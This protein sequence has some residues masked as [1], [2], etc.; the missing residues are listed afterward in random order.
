MVITSNEP[1]IKFGKQI[2]TE[3]QKLI[4]RGDLDQNLV[5]N[6]ELLNACYP[7]KLSISVKYRNQEVSAEQ[8]LYYHY[9]QNL[10]I[11]RTPEDYQNWKENNE[12][13]EEDERMIFIA[14]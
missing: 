4:D 8:E 7:M 10:H 11:E 6:K 14:K 3:A 9:C 13:Y 2:D 12:N 5:L 1:I